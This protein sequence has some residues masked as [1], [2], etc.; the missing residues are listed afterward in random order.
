MPYLMMTLSSFVM[1]CA[2][3][4]HPFGHY[5]TSLPS[6]KRVLLPL[7]SQEEVSGIE[8]RKR[9]E[10]KIQQLGRI[11]QQQSMATADFYPKKQN[12]TELSEFTLVIDNKEIIERDYQINLFHNQYDVTDSWLRNSQITFNHQYTKMK[13]HFKGLKLLADTDHQILIRFQNDRF[14][15]AQFF[16]Y[17]EPTCSMSDLSELKKISPFDVNPQLV[18]AIDK[19]SH[20]ENINPRFIAGLIAQESAFNSKAVSHAKAIGLTQVTNLAQVHILQNKKSW[21]THDAID[22]YSVPIIKTMILTG[23]INSKNEWRLNENLSIEGGI[24]FLKYLEKYWLRPE[25]RELIHRH[26]GDDINHVLNELI[27]ASYNS[28]AYRVKLA[29]KKYGKRWRKDSDQ[30]HEAR[31]YVKKVNSYC[32]HF[33]PEDRDAVAKL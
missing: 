11:P 14:T 21:P 24:T 8:H 26:Y 2:G 23:T 19:I 6:E 5:G 15:E 22:E 33:E 7:N 16:R 20:Q 1:S 28:G 4:T 10:K 18:D 32:Y 3:P 13:I 17:S 9:D 27:L 31:K 12:L 25:N 29:L 30:L